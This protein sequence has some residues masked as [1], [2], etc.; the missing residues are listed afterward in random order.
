M[1]KSFTRAA[2]KCSRPRL[3]RC[4][5][6]AI[7][8]SLGDNFRL[9]QDFFSHKEQVQLLAAS[10][11]ALDVQESRRYKRMREKHERP[12]LTD[13]MPLQ[14]VFYPD[15][16]YKFEQGHFDAVI[17]DYRERLVEA[18]PADL[19]QYRPGVSRLFDKLHPLYPSQDIQMHLLHLASIGEIHPHVDNLEASGSWIL[20]VS[21]GSPRV[22]R[23]ES[24]GCEPFEVLLPSGSVYVQRDDVR[25]NYKH[26]IL[27]P[28]ATA[29]SASNHQRLS[30]MI[31]DRLASKETPIV[32]S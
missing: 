30:I 19:E 7:K 17:H 28:Q 25:F 13:D 8:D 24:E 23:L 3:L 26:S 6:T 29:R 20:G 4:Y 5:A 31:R 14:D 21:L 11:A 10:L 22:L 12:E 27:K 32:P 1:L 18:G 15:N 16:C 2:T 9:Y